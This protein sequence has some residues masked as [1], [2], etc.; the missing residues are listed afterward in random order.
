MSAEKIPQY[1]S[2]N[3]MVNM[4]T[5]DFKIDFAI[6]SPDSFEMLA[7]V[8]MSPQHFK[9]FVGVLNQNLISYEQ[10]F[11]M[12]NL[13]PN[14]DNLQGMVQQGSI[15]VIQGPDNDHRQPE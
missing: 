5:F 11:G 3:A 4:S 9:A 12:I 13:E 6:G 2:N 15:Q 10:L 1:Y 14:N 8:R 7:E